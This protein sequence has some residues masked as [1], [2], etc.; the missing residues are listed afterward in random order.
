VTRDPALI[1]ELLVLPHQFRSRLE[2]KA[3]TRL[4]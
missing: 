3:I 2:R 1:S 4:P